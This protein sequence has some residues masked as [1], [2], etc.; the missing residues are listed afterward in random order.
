MFGSKTRDVIFASRLEKR[1]VLVKMVEKSRLRDNVK[2]RLV[3]K[4]SF[5]DK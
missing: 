5:A 4:K 3:R 1:T 2:M